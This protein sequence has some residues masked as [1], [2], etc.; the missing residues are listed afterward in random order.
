M[1]RLGRPLYRSV[2]LVSKIPNPHLFLTNNDPPP[3]HTVPTT[4]LTLI[5]P[6]A[7]GGSYYFA[8]RS[9]NA[10]RASRHEADMRRKRLTE[11]LEFNAMHDPATRKTQHRPI[12]HAASPSDEASEDPAPTEHRLGL[13]KSKYEPKE[14]Y[15]AKKGDRFS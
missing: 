15:R 2:Q 10:D 4:S 5:L 7:G 1:A 8:K 13:E 12:D 14:L 11:Q 9:I 3:S 6:L